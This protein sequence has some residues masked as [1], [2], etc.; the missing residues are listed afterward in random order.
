MV[1]PA[2]ASGCFAD[3]QGFPTSVQ[4]AANAG[5]D[6]NAIRNNLI[7]VVRALGI[8]A[9]VQQFGAIFEVHG[10]EV[11]PATAPDEALTLERVDDLLRHRVLPAAFFPAP[12]IRLRWIE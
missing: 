4:G 8:T 5:A 12:I 1:S 9:S 10:V 3:S 7:R 6:K 2:S 11:I